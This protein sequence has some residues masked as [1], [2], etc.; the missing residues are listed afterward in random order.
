MENYVNYIKKF[1]T[2]NSVLRYLLFDIIVIIFFIYITNIIVDVNAFI[3]SILILFNFFL[4][5]YII[6]KYI[7]DVFSIILFFALTTLFFGFVIRPI[8]S[9]KM[10]YFLLYNNDIEDTTKIFFFNIALTLNIIATIF[11]L[12]GYNIGRKFK[13]IHLIK[14]NHYNVLK[15]KYITILLL[16]FCLFLFFIFLQIT[17]PSFLA[18]NRNVSVTNLFTLGKYFFVI[19]PLLTYLPS[20]SL[21]Y[22]LNRKRAKTLFGKYFFFLVVSFIS[23]LILFLFYQRGYILAGVFGIIAVLKKYQK[24]SFRRLIIFGFIGIFIAFFARD[25]YFLIFG[26]NT[27]SNNANL[28]FIYNELLYS[29]NFDY[30]D[31]YVN[32]LNYIQHNHITFGTNLIAQIFRFLPFSIRKNLPFLTMTDILNRL[33]DPI[34]YENGFG[35]TVPILIDFM[36]AF[37]VFGILLMVLPGFFVGISDQIINRKNENIGEIILSLALFNI[38]SL[39][40]PLDLQS[41]AL[42]LLIF[43]IIVIFI[44]SKS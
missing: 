44:K 42:N 1:I 38:G 28:N 13:L 20:L 4:V 10:N 30:L 39:W 12:L 19:V 8:L 24:M 43:L 5:L 36:G 27:F 37:G 29:P 25:I 18:T 26:V 16:L 33:N 31:V 22:C 9:I 32:F 14:N 21:I 40:G 35:F 17:G 11:Y 41:I 3:S 34:G 6:G 23:I 15:L 2:T 7:K